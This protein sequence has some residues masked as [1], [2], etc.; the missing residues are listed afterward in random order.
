MAVQAAFR[1]AAAFPAAPPSA[2]DKEP[3]GGYG[4]MA[5][6]ATGYAQI[7]RGSLNSRAS[8]RE[9]GGGLQPRASEVP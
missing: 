2:Q 5:I 7:P 1:V 4:R 9:S 6:A 8:S 3:G